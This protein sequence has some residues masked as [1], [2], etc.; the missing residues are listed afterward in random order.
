MKRFFSAITKVLIFILLILMIVVLYINYKE[1]VKDF[2][3]SRFKETIYIGDLVVQVTI[4]DDTE[5][6]RQGLSGVTSLDEL[7]GK[8]FVFDESD[9]YGIWMKDM[10]FPIDIIWI[11][12]ELK[13]VHIE[14]NIGPSTFPK[15]FR[16]DVPARFV[17]E[18]NSYFAKTFKVD[19]GDRVILPAK[20]LPKDIK[21][22]LQ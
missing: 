14:E 22:N 21:Q 9:R 5:E 20:A 15:V 12:D 8:L 16:P 7:E 13:I 11:S 2:F 6:R 3:A 18:T 10:N 1:P 17:L 19:V 4:A